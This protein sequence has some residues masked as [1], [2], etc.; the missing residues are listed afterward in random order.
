MEISSTPGVIQHAQLLWSQPLARTSLFICFRT[1]PR[2]S[3]MTNV[4]GM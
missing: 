3:V 1:L 4:M 2:Y